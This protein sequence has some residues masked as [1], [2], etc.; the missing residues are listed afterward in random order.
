MVTYRY[1]ANGNVVERAGGEGTVRYTYD[2][3]NQLTRVDF[4]DGTWVRY[5]YD[6]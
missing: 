3:R 1:D 4:P 5:A 6:A 2:S